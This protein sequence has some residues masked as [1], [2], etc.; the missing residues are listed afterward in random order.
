MCMGCEACVWDAKH[1][2]GMRS[3]CM[4]CEACVWDAK[5]CIVLFYSFYNYN[6]N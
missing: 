4:G 5:G 6:K 2:Y 1:V 3:M